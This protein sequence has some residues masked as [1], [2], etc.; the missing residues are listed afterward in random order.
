MIAYLANT[1][2][3][4]SIAMTAVSTLLRLFLPLSFTAQ[5]SGTYVDIAA[6]GLFFSTLKVVL[7]PISIG[8]LLNRYFPNT[9]QKCVPLAPPVAVVLITLIV[10]S[11]IGQGSAIILSAGLQCFTPF[12]FYI[13]W[14]SCWLF[15]QLLVAEKSFC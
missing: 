10:A 9:T 5:L 2:V 8:I 12:L 11:I 6:S 1:H 15:F 7:L 3:A 13:F 4:L 14:I